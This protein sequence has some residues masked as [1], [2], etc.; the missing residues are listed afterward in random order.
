MITA[1]REVIV[2]PQANRSALS[3][4]SAWRSVHEPTD[5]RAVWTERI[6]LA[7]S[8]TAAA[9]RFI[10]LDRTSPIAKTSGWLVSNGSGRRPSSAQVA[11]SNAPSS[12]TP[13]GR[14][15]SPRRRPRPGPDR[16]PW[17]PA[18]SP[19]NRCPRPRTPPTGRAAGSG[20]GRRSVGLQPRPMLIADRRER[21]IAVVGHQLSRLPCG[22]YRVFRAARAAAQEL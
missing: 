16:R 21:L 2:G 20:S 8:P 14:R 15:S 5:P 13:P 9:A 7:L 6:A 17:P 1:I 3:R 10:D 12:W 19:R 4:R 18:P 22:S 11:P